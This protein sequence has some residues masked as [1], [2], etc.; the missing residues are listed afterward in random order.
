MGNVVLALRRLKVPRLSNQ[1]NVRAFS[2][3]ET[4]RGRVRHWRLFNSLL[5]LCSACCG[6]AGSHVFKRHNRS[7]CRGLKKTKTFSTKLLFFLFF[8]LRRIQLCCC[9]DKS[10]TWAPDRVKAP[11][12]AGIPQCLAI[13]K[14]I[15][16]CTLAL[17]YLLLVCHFTMKM[18]CSVQATATSQLA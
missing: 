7:F 18:K 1:R 13:L 16:V 4:S 9:S 17:L 15:N 8:S 6:A 12:H 2:F 10:N 5:I 14:M 3:W 11:V